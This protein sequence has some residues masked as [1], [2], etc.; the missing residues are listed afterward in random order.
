MERDAAELFWFVL[1]CSELFW[2]ELFWLLV[3]GV[4][5]VED[6][7]N[8]FAEVRIVPDKFWNCGVPAPP[9]V[10]PGKNPKTFTY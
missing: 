2:L 1:I 8:P 4:V 6:G 3:N 9:R 7:I 5:A 10:E